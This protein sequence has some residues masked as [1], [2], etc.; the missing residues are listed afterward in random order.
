MT[1][2]QIECFIEAAKTGSFGKAGAKLYISQ[3]TISR[4]IKALE[5]ELG[6]PL[7]DR[8][9]TGVQLTEAG[10]LLYEKWKSMLVEYRSAIDQARDVFLGED[11]KVRIGIMDSGAQVQDIIQ[12]LIR[13]NEKYPDLD[14]E[15]SIYSANELLQSLEAG[16]AHIIFALAEDMP[17][18]NGMHVLPLEHF[19][20]EVGIVFANNHPLSKRKKIETKHLAGQKIGVLSRT[21][22]SDHMSNVKK[23]FETS[24]LGDQVLI[25]E[26]SSVG[27][28]QMA[29]ITGKCVTVMFRYIS[30]GIE[31]KVKF[32]P[33]DIE[34]LDH[35]MVVACK[36]EKYLVKAKNIAQE[37]DK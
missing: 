23:L 9:R 8:S 12:G 10:N 22:T 34:W 16:E 25:K 30:N 1:I 6:F 32:L 14:V 5:D 11:K 18:R 27:N 24:G 15:Y 21:L 13:F 31:D 33:L 37:F 28:L 3:Q 20:E 17:N 19:H 4:Q 29:L 26:Y 36:N 35:R 7:F 2:T